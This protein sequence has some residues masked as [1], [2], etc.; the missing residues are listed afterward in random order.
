MVSSCE[1]LDL[2]LEMAALAKKYGAPRVDYF[3]GGTWRLWW[4]DLHTHPSAGIRGDLSSQG[5]TLEEAI[6]RLKDHVTKYVV[7]RGGNCRSGVCP[8][9]S[10]DLY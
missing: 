6:V 10:D 9:Y 4:T 1:Q 3:I 7:R 5:K 2:N 8:E